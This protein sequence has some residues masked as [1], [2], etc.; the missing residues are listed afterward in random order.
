[1]GSGAGG[2]GDRTRN[3]VL[4]KGPESADKHLQDIWLGGGSPGPPHFTLLKGRRT[5]A[6]GQLAGAPV[7]KPRSPLEDPPGEGN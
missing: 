4:G 7:L 5:R 3:S 6:L 2:E 1:M